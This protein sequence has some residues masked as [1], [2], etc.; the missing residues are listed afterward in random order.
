MHNRKHQFGQ[1]IELFSGARYLNITHHIDYH[2]G[3]C[4]TKDTNTLWK[5]TFNY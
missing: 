1:L 2:C 4:V 5:L 3:M